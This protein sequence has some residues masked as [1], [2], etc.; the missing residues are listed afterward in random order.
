MEK[1]NLK[2][3]IMTIAL[4]ILANILWAVI[5]DYLA[6]KFIIYLIEVSQ[7]F[8]EQ[9]FR[10]IAT[11]DTM[12]LQK[13]TLSIIYLLFFNFLIFVSFLIYYFFSLLRLKFEGIKA[14][15]IKI[16]EDVYQKKNN[17]VE[18]SIEEVEKDYENLMNGISK[19]EKSY[20]KLSLFLVVVVS[21]TVF[22][23][24]SMY[25]YAQF[26]NNYIYDSISYYNYL[27]R[28]N[29]ISLSD[30]EE[31]NYT[32]K[33]T[34]IKNKN[35]YLEIIKELEVMAFENNLGVNTYPN[36]RKENDIL[37]DHRNYLYGIK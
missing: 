14:R 20:R 3:V 28:V 15:A 25:F 6:P 9:I 5:A 29:S 37:S 10:Q 11:R 23:C 31:R 32:T 7:S 27:L 8:D 19:S 2:T 24:V 13:N 17:N 21:L 34:Q 12:F 22:G 36:V 16:G 33:F 4:S 1:F 35:D 30:Q 26:K 18:V